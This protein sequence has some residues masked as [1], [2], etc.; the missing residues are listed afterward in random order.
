MSLYLISFMKHTRR[1]VRC[2]CTSSQVYLEFVSV[3]LVGPYIGHILSCFSGVSAPLISCIYTLSYSGVSRGLRTAGVYGGPI[4][5]W[6][7]EKNINNNLF[8]VSII[9]II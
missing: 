2:I 1:C 4:W 8:A 7:R 6:R 5:G 3:V 9:I